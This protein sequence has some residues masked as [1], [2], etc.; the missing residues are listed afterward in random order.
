M[1]PNQLANVRRLMKEHRARRIAAANRA[2][3]QRDAAIMRGITAEAARVSQCDAA[4]ARD[5]AVYS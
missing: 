1:T 5:D 2:A 4:S 3:D